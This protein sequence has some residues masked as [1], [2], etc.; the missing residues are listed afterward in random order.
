MFNTMKRLVSLVLCVV[1]VCA[2]LPAAASA[3]E[4][5]TVRVLNQAENGSFYFT[6]EAESALRQEAPL[7]NAGENL[8]PL[9]K[10][11]DLQWGYVTDWRWNAETQQ[12]ELYLAEKPGGAVWKPAEPYQAETRLEYID[13]ATGEVESSIW[14]SRSATSMPEWMSSEHFIWDD[15]ESG[16]YKFAVTAIGDNITY[17]DSETAESASWTYVRPS[18]KVATPS[19]PVWSWPNMSWTAP[20]DMTGVEEYEV[21]M[22]FAEN[23]ESEPYCIYSHYVGSNTESSVIDVEV[24]QHGVGFY[25]FRVRA[26]SSDITVYC[27][28]DWSEMSEPYNL[29]K[30]SDGVEGELESIL[31]NGGTADQIRDS[32]SNLD[33]EDLKSAMLADQDNTGAVQKIADLEAAVGVNTNIAVSEDAPAIDQSKVSIVGAG[34][35]TLE[36][37]NED[38]TL[39]I[40]APESEDH[41]LPALYDSTVSVSFSMD[42]D[43]VA[44]TEN[45]E[46]PVKITLPIP[47]NINPDF[48]VILHYHVDGTME[49]IMPYV[50]SEGGQYYAAFVLT[51]FSD[52]VM[53]EPIFVDVPDDIW[54]TDAVLWAVDEGITQGYGSEYTFCPDQ[55]CTRGEIVTFLW[56]AAGKPAPAS[57][58]NPFKD[59]PANK[60][61]TDAVLWAV[62]QGITDGYGSSTTFAPDVTCTRDQI[63]TFLWRYFG[64][65][66]PASNQ[67]PFIDVAAGQWFTDAI[68]WAAEEGITQGM[69]SNN[70]FCPKNDCSRAQIVTF[71]FRAMD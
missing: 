55:P 54:Y 6:Y 61:Y 24:Q 39:N 43:N 62:E 17:C 12:G 33:D 63:A 18:A 16:T 41:V 53:I 48:L 44:D 11:T 59:V 28:G 31:S 32:V 25:S 29:K 20:A 30:L 56:R 3:A 52:F 37:S 27:N 2:L 58:N 46:V 4:E 8:I 23:A 10:A 50:Y 38:I 51:S 45:L 22:Y 35:N 26:L 5:N 36:N 68:L 66:A 34:L 67:N 15:F 60:W 13:V 69:G 42:L 40:G 71:L 65:P 9:G 14:W 57:S 70:T 1:F 64:E 19:A 7:L 21:E 47:E 49:E